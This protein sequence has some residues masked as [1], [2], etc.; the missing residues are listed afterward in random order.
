MPLIA[1]GD[2]RAFRALMSRHM[3]R[4]IRLAQGIVRNESDADDVAQ[5]AFLRIWRRA[6]SFDAK[7]A[8]FTT[9]MHQIV[10]N[11]AIDRVRRPRTEPIEAAATIADDSPGQLAAMVEKEEHRTMLD[12]L[13]A[14]PERQRAAITLFHFE[15]LSGRESA[16]AMD[17]SESAFES[18]L[19]RARTTLKQSVQTAL[20]RRG[21]TP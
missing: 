4:A 1:A 2:H 21:R 8:R 3:R 7:V 9:W 20:Q 6:A 19:W 12:A 18:L 11:L 15:G 13:A 5:E 14:M 16:Q 17:L 10:V